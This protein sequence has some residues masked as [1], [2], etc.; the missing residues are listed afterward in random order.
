MPSDI[1][2]NF[3][4][5][6]ALVPERTKRVRHGRREERFNGWRLTLCPLWLQEAMPLATMVLRYQ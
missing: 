3:L 5:T 4:K 1:E 6:V 2:G